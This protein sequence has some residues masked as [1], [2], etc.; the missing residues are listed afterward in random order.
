MKLKHNISGMNV[1]SRIPVKPDD[2]AVKRETARTSVRHLLSLS[3]LDSEDIACLVNRSVEFA[4]GQRYGCNS[5]EGKIVG[6]YFRKPSTRTR[7]SFTVG[8]LRLNAKIIAYGPTDLQLVTGETIEDT[9][10]VLSGYL[11][12][13]VIRTNEAIGEMKALAHQ[14]EMAVINAMSE[15]EHPTQAIADLST[16][17]ERFG[18]LEGLHIL[19]LGEGN[20]TAAALALAIAKIPGMKITFLTPEGYGL[21]DSIL[22]Q[23]YRFGKQSGA[24][25]EQRHKPLQLPKSADVVY[26][27]RWRTMGVSHADPNWG[28]K[29]LPYRVTSDLM[30]R[31]SKASGTIFLHD[32]P[33]VRGEEVSD[34]VLNS[35]QSLAWR[36][37]RHKM[38]SAMAILEWCLGNNA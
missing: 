24:E 25:I 15:H 35:L 6:I 29:F 36:Q 18:R 4:S 22:E 27:T 12:G 16:M 19:Y 26:T 9:A 32:L 28:E 7:S 14:G 2:F 10:R 37:V 20:N 38:F 13:F 11:D 30:R 23:S 8:A 5:L 1:S 3:D 34:E 33:A 21:P 17:K 31:V